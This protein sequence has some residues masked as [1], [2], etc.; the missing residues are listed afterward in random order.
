MS[1]LHGPESLGRTRLPRLLRA[2]RKAPGKMN[3][4]APVRR[5]RVLAELP[6]VGAGATSG[7]WLRWCMGGEEA[8]PDQL[9][10]LGPALA[11][12]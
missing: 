1:D 6:Q 3:I 8:A 10:G 5:D 9:E 11:P 7:F 4:L 2:P 12:S